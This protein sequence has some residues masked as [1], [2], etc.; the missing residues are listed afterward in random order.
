MLDIKNIRE[1]FTL[2]KKSLENRNTNINLENVIIADDKRKEILFELEELRYKRN[3]AS[4]K[5]A[6]LKRA[7]IDAANLIVKMREVSVQIKTLEK[8]LSG[9]QADI[10]KRLL[11]IPNIPHL[12]VPTG[13]SEID[14]KLVKQGYDI[15][16]GHGNGPQVGNVLLQHE[17]GFKEYGVPKMPIDVCVA[18]TQGSIG[19]M[20]SIRE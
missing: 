13:T 8:K 9:I 1:N 16:I 11:L 19:Y 4:N 20:I 7:K 14:N 12:S 2:I 10:M 18:E 3:S 17:A 5:I 6:E 15:V